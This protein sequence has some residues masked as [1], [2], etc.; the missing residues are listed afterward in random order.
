MNPSQSSCP[1]R[2]LAESPFAAVDVCS[3]GMM[4]L[5]VGAVTIRFTPR[6]LS[7]LLATLGRAVAVH[8]AHGAV[9]KAMGHAERGCA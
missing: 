8:A 5:H 7:E 2:R 3:C 1:R 9:A 4:Q 6:A